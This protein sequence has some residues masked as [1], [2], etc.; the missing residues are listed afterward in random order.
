N[1]PGNRS[2]NE[3]CFFTDIAPTIYDLVGISPSANKG[4]AP[5]TGKSMRPH[6]QNPRIP[7]YEEGDGIGLEAGNSAAYFMG[8]YKIVKNNKPLGD[9]Q[10][11]LYNLRKDPCETTDL[12]AQEPLRFQ[13]ML[14][15]YEAFAKEVGVLVMPPNYDAQS[16]VGKKSM[17]AVANPFR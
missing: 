1:I 5:I 15:R 8:N 6:I 13:M 4:Y 3:F 10:W 11:R 16:E 2:D 17:K 9:S 14:S 7:I 12:A